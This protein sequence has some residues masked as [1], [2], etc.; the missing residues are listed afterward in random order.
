M[1]NCRDVEGGLAGAGE[2][3]ETKAAVAG[4]SVVD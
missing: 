2:F 1:D 3:A 4:A